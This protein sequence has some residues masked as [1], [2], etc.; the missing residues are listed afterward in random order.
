MAHVEA[1]L[2][3]TPTVSIKDFIDGLQ[4]SDDPEDVVLLMQALQLNRIKVGDLIVAHGV[5]FC[6]DCFVRISAR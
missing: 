6:C 5:R 3:E 4:L 2:S 1:I